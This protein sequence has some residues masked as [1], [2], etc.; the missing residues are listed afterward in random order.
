[1]LLDTFVLRSKGFSYIGC[2]SQSKT[3]LDRYN[4]VYS[5]SELTSRLADKQYC[6]VDSEAALRNVVARLSVYGTVRAVQLSHN[7]F[8]IAWAKHKPKSVVRH[9]WRVLY[10]NIDNR[11]YDWS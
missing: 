8:L 5:V 1:M 3:V 10:T 2:Y 7:S 9:A 4:T 6:Y 11:E